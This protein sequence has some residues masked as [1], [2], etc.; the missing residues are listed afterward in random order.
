M[1]SLAV[2]RL[3]LYTSNA[4]GMGSIPGL[5]TKILHAIW[6]DQNK[7]KQKTQKPILHIGNI[8]K[9]QN[10]AVRNQIILSKKW[11]KDFYRHL[12]KEDTQM[13]NNMKRCSQSYQRNT[14]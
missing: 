3:R 14:M 2:K 10:L 8:Q 13:E 5:G 9:T 4:G 1:T 6:C 7:T 11:A 12:K